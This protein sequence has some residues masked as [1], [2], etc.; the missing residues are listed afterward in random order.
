MLR[1]IVEHETGDVVKK[2]SVLKPGLGDK[3]LRK[4][5]EVLM[6]E[7]PEEDCCSI[8]FQRENKCERKACEVVLEMLPEVL[9]AKHIAEYLHV[10]PR[11][12]Y[13][14]MKDS[15]SKGGLKVFR[16]GKVCRVYKRDFEAWL[17]LHE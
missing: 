14:W 11:A 4:V 13:G 2:E 6:V 8:D 7:K 16:I 9:T 5:V 12:V 15:S 3:A 1:I 17:K 10:T